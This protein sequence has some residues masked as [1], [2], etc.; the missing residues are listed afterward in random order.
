MMSIREGATENEFLS[1][2]TYISAYIDGDYKIDGVAQ[3]KAPNYK[4]DFSERLDNRF[5]VSEVYDQQE[6]T[7]ELEKFVSNAEEDVIYDAS[8]ETYLKLVEASGENLTIIFL[9]LEKPKVS[10]MF[11]LL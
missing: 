4:V 2:E 3:R 8:G 5:K 6:V 1:Q 7:F 10:I 11:Y 9:R